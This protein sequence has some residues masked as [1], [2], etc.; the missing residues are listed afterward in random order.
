MIAMVSWFL[1]PLFCASFAK[2]LQ[3]SGESTMVALDELDRVAV[4][5]VVGDVTISGKQVA[6]AIRT[7][8]ISMDPPKE[9][10]RTLV[11]LTTEH[12]IDREAVRSELGDTVG[13]S[14]MKMKL[15]E[16]EQQ[17]SSVDRTMEEHLAEAGLSSAEFYQELH[18]DLVWKKHTSQLTTELAIEKHWESHRREWD[19]TQMGVDQI[20]LLW[21]EVGDEEGR[22]QLRLKAAMIAEEVAGGSLSWREAVT[23][24]SMS[25]LRDRDGADSIRW[26]GRFGPMPEAFNG[27]AFGLEPGEISPPVE[28]PVGI[29]VI[30][31]IAIRAGSLVMN[32]VRSD[33]AKSI[34]SGEFRT[35]AGRARKK[36]N[37]EYGQWM[38][39]D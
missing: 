30:R 9:V 31:C 25:P 24:W 33:I 15:S 16:I 26:V 17:L 14:R 28:T 1:L 23:R 32:D 35:I 22:Q 36:L 8:N 19:G 2:P 4:M 7:A 21:P 12:L 13:P 38:L 27:A 39:D 11:S 10:S 20:L 5:A 3:I 37:I 34:V 6:R 29:H 18:W